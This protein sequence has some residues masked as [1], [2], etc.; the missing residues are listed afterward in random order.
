[1]KVFYGLYN[2]R[3][4]DKT[5][6]MQ[7]LL[8][9]NFKSIEVN[10]NDIE[11]TIEFLRKDFSMINNYHGW[12][13]LIPKKCKMVRFIENNVAPLDSKQL[14]KE[15][16]ISHNNEEYELYASFGVAKTSSVWKLKV[17]IY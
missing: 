6:L 7:G 11:K 8:P 10:E 3:G 15:V 9:S 5:L 2:K 16:I 12:Y 4:N 17:V 13:C 1:M 14:K